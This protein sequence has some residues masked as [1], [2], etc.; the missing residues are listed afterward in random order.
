MNY[1][2]KEV[3]D[4]KSNQKKEK[5]QVLDLQE[6]MAKISLKLETLKISAHLN[7]QQ[8][9]EEHDEALNAANDNGTTENI[10]ELDKLR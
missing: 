1:E 10:E 3:N 2:L 9:K 8:L 6:L 7:M 5:Y 4:A